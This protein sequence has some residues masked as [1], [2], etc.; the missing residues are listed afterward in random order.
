M[1]ALR[2]RTP[3]NTV[4]QKT[5]TVEV[6][7]LAQVLKP[8]SDDSKEMSDHFSRTACSVMG[9][10]YGISP[11]LRFFWDSLCSIVA[12]DML[13]LVRLP[14]LALDFKNIFSRRRI[15]A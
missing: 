8:H 10:Q 12:I 13:I 7:P 3:L 2:P 9:H 6:R 4:R 11:G 5:D 1:S 15:R 14:V